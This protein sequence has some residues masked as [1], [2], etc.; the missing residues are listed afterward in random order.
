VATTIVPWTSLWLRHYEVWHVTGEWWGGGEHPEIG[1]SAV[2]PLQI[3][4]GLV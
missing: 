4:R 2:T 3:A 1:Q